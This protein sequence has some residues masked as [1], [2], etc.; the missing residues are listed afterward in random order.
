MAVSAGWA[1][2]LALRGDGSVLAWG[3]NDYGQTNVAGLPTNII[4][5]AAG[6]YHSAALR[7]DGSVVT[8]GWDV[9]VPAQAT[10]I[11]AIAAGWEHCLGLR[12]DGT[13]IG[14]G[15]NTY[16]QS[17]VPNSA[18]GVVA[19]AA[20][21]Y[22]NLAL[23]ADG[24]VV[25]WGLGAFGVTNVP[26]T[27]ASVT[28]VAAGEA[29]SLMLVGSGSPQ[30]SR[31]PVPA[32]AVIGGQVILSADVSGAFPLTLQW[33]HNGIAISGA[34]NRF[35]LLANLQSADAG[36]YVLVVSN[37]FG[38]QSSQAAQVTVQGGPAIMSQTGFQN[39][40]LGGSA[41]LSATVVGAAPLSF[42]WQFNGTNLVDGPRLTGTHSTQLCLSGAVYA[43]SGGYNLIATGPYG[44]TTGPV[45]QVSVS[46]I[47]AWGDNSGSQLHVPAGTRDVIT[48][49]AG[50]AHVLALH[51]NGTVS[52]W[53]DDSF[54]QTDVPAS[55]TNIVAVAAGDYHSLALR[56]DGTVLAWGNN[57]YG[58][59]N[60]PTIATP[61]R[62]IAAG[63][64]HNVALLI[65]GTVVS[66]GLAPYFWVPPTNAT[67]IA[68]GC[69]Y[70][71]ALRPDGT[72]SAPYVP[73]GGS[74]VP[75]TATNVVSIAAGGFHALGLRGDGMVVAWGHDDYGQID[76]PTFP[77]NVVQLSGGGDHSLAL[78]ANG[79][80]V[81]WGA[82]DSGQAL[83]PAAATNVVAIAAGGSSSFALA[84]E[85]P[86]AGPLQFEPVN[87]AAAAGQGT[88]HLRLTGMTAQGPVIIYASSDLVNWQP[89]YTNP[90]AL[91]TLDYLDTSGSIQPSR[92]YQA[93]ETR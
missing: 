88:F 57:T 3:N 12:A 19:I 86:T 46:L 37:G 9:P 28:A 53:G 73:S 68:A 71:M 72:V 25:A 74:P 1:H 36:S 63:A 79:Q 24:T 42:Q 93:T 61:V 56:A 84:S 20:G 58:Q 40:L 41:C 10:N 69:F 7:A 8:W 77:T 34:T 43:D 45:T 48:L 18:T 51:G 47:L 76:L 70:S 15:D 52:A 14:W 81:A 80:V 22:H 89:I 44:S 21:Y 38:Q 59:T 75:A 33:Y 85:T 91:G 31:Q 65:G 64:D 55:A 13:V 92:Y 54:G 78:L 27:L 26:A 50:A 87:G 4:A 67:A 29:H 11:I 30:V 2:T 60:I 49:A 32:T 16:G 66:W 39:V 35:L 82:N 62:A 17:S 5:V 6:Y 23:R 83:V 90:P